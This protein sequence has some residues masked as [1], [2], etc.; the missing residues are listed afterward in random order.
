MN[1]QSDK[2]SLVN[3]LLKLSSSDML[4]MHMP[5]GK[6]K[7]SGFSDPFRIDITEITDFDNL[8]HPEG[9][10]K[11]EM[12]RAASLY[13][14]DETLFGTNGSTGAVLAAICGALGRG[15][16][17]LVGRNCHISVYHAIELM[18]LD[19]VYLI[20]ETEDAA[21]GIYGSILPGD[22]QKALDENR[23]IRAVILT[24]PTYEGV[25]SDIRS[26]AEICHERGIVLIVDE[27]HGA[28]FGFGGG[29][30]ETSVRLGADAVIQ[31]M[32][33]TLP[34]LTQA[35]LLHLSGPWID[36]ARVRHY[37]DIFQT[38]SPSYV[39]M[40]SMSRCLSWLE[41][42][43]RDAMQSYGRRI[44]R[45][46]KRL[47]ALT[48]ARLFAPDS[49]QTDPG[50]IVMRVP[51]GPSAA[52]WL[53][54]NKHI[55]LEMT[56]LRYFIAMTSP[57]DTDRD[58]ERFAGALEEM[59]TVRFPQERASAAAFLTGDLPARKCR[60][61]EALDAPAGD[62]A[63][64]KACGRTAAEQV[65]LYPPG[66]PTVL[67]GEMFGRREIAVLRAAR[68]TGLQILGLHEGMVRCLK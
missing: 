1:S 60:I 53:R 5:G 12:E 42:D 28:H 11:K 57:V 65:C 26:I 21:C 20:P 35:A 19:P 68:E 64:E 23:D 39:I 54:E 43:G 29:F 62:V 63:L 59:D 18:N 50:K 32:H 2:D 30:P 17:C 7:A 24:S 16:K 66:I 15:D 33:K 51:D 31:S 55:E 25:V 45:L 40:G 3:R 34:A 9:I 8:H 36:R 58:L 47:S 4:P 46:R 22:V 37:W 52:A 67:P 6:R 61:A 10:I 38:T 56:S 14:A 27:A 44:A 41:D 49:S 48:G 13:G